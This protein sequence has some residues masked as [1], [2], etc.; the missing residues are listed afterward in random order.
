MSLV[1][2]LVPITVLCAVAESVG[3]GTGLACSVFVMLHF[4]AD[5]F[6]TSS[7]MRFGMRWMYSSFKIS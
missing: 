2:A 6:M 7:T 4:C 5:V 1:T 3:E